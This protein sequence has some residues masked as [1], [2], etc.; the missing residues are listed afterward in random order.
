MMPCR[1]ILLAAKEQHARPNARFQVHRSM[2]RLVGNDRHSP[3]GV[4]L[5]TI[6]TRTLQ[7]LWMA[8]VVEIN[9]PD[10]LEQYQLVWNSLLPKTPRASFFHTYDWLQL[11][12]KHFGHDK[13]LRVLVVRSD[14]TPFGIVPLCINRERYQ[15]GDVRVLTYPLS[16]WGMWYGPIGP[17]QSACMFMALKHLSQTSRDWDMIDLRWSAAGPHDRNATGRAIRAVGWQPRKIAYQSNSVIRF[18]GTDY[19]SYLASLNKKW[20]HEIRRQTRVLER[21]GK[22]TFHRHRPA[23]KGWGDG[24]PRWDLFDDCM[25]ISQQSWQ[26][27]S[28]TG[29]TLCHPHVRGFLHDCHAT[30]ARIGML[31]MAVLKIDGRPAAYQYNYHRHGRVFGLRMGYDPAFSQQGVG[32]ILMNRLIEDSFERNDQTLDLGIGDFAFKRRFR[33]EV[34]TSYRYACYPWRSWR[35]QGVRFSR[36]MKQRLRSNDPVSAPKGA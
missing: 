18:A 33:T 16:D 14:G 13:Q 30:A 7:V 11:Y 3:C 17:D 32:K 36:W 10:E 4:R 8:D 35:S 25:Q 1:N 26:S 2:F 5:R 27:K 24:Q 22:V 9:D 34:E 15:V 28:T 23:G 31:D 20:R 6:D 12:W 19:E 29:N 21:A